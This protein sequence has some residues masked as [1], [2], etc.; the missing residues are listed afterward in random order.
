MRKFPVAASIAAL[1]V[2]V[3]ANA[4][5][6]QILLNGGFEGITTSSSVGGVT[7]NS[8]PTGWTPNAAFNQT[9]LNFQNNANQHSGQSALQI[10]NFDDQDLASLSQTFSDIA[11]EVY[12]VDFWTLSGGTND[13]VAFLRVSVGAAGLTYDDTIVGYVNGGFS[14]TG[15]G[16]DTITIAGKTNPSEWFVDDVSISDTGRN[17]GPSGPGGGAGGVPEPASWALMILGFGGVGAALRRRQGAAA[18]A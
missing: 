3:V 6:A 7:N 9:G 14:F 2:L 15:T 18:L 17:V 4:A 12:N 11:G 16:S 1:G 13:P 5:Q 10:G 8:V